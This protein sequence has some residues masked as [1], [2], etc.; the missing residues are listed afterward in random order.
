MATENIQ[1]NKKASPKRAKK[2]QHIGLVKNDAYLEPFED[3]IKGRHNHAAWKISQLTKNGKLTLSD[4]ASGYDYYGLHKLSRGWVFREWA[5]NATDIYLV[6]DFNNWQENEKYR[7]KRIEGT[8]NWELKLSEKAIQHGQ[9]YKMHV[10]WNGGEGERIPA[11]AQ[12]VVQ[13]ENTKIFSAQVWNL[14]QPYVWKRKT[15][16]AK[17]DPLLIYECHIGMGEDAEKVG[18]YTEFKENVLPRVV[19]DGYNA[20]QIMAIQEHPYYGSF[21]Y[22]VSSFFCSKFAFRHTRRAQSAH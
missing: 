10:R 22:H 5:P 9:L 3:A 18:T 12:R 1:N 14:Q 16:R 21:G 11:W 8:G 2:P 6:G 17:R 15:F 20:I 7:C 4:F 13:D 19:R